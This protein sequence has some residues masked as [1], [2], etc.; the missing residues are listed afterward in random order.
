MSALA[1]VDASDE[2]RV[3]LERPLSGGV[4]VLYRPSEVR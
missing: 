4:Y 1:T 2:L 3:A